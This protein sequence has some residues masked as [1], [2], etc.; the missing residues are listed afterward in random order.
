ML[1][2]QSAIRHISYTELDAMLRELAYRAR[3]TVQGIKP[4]TQRD[5]VPAALLAHFLKVP[6][7]KGTEFS[8]FSDATTDICLFKKEYDSEHYNRNV[9][10]KYGFRNLRK[11]FSNRN[12]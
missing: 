7:G 10:Q 3:G 2:K 1:L 9:K 6:Y 8:I 5:E 12:Q 11:T 4:Q